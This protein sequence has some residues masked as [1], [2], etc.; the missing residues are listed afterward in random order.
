MNEPNSQQYDDLVFVRSSSSSRSSSGIIDSIWRPPS[1]NDTTSVSDAAAAAAA[2][3]ISPSVLPYHNLSSFLP[4]SRLGGALGASV[5]FIFIVFGVLGDTLIILAILS[6]R[7]LRKNIVNIFIVSLQLNDLF[8]IGFNQS[9]VGLSYLLMKWHGPYIICEI[10]VYTSIICTGT[11]L[12]HHALIAIHRYK[13]T[14][15]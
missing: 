12:W 5:A 15:L 1:L 6:K 9:L 8:N 7:E 2:A 11:L 3:F 10:F 4:P 14:Y 13:Y